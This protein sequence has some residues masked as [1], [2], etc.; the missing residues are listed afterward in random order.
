[1]ET[2]LTDAYFSGTTTAQTD[3]SGFMGAS[4]SQ[5]SGGAQAL[6]AIAGAYSAYTA[7]KMQKYAYDH[8]AAMTEINAK[9]Q[10]I[11]AQFMITD[12]QDQLSQ[13]LALMN[14]MAAAGGRSGGSVANLAQTSTSNLNKDAERIKTT[15]KARSVSSLMTSQAYRS[16]GDYMNRKSL[17]EAGSGLTAGLSKAVGYF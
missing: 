7:G 12:K 5:W 15:G 3:S 9:Q 4:A 2:P 10:E 17:L 14:V 8:Q 11:E 1:M 13:N 6:S 16:T